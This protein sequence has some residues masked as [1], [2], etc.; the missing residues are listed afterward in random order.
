MS[1]LTKGNYTQ[2]EQKTRNRLKWLLIYIPFVI[3]PLVTPASFIFLGMVNATFFSKQQKT[4]N[5]AKSVAVEKP[6]MQ[7]LPTTPA[8]P[9]SAPRKSNV[10]EIRKT[11]A[12]PLPQPSAAVAVEP[13][14]A[15]APD[16]ETVWGE[17][18]AQAKTRSAL[19]ITR[20]KAKRSGALGAARVAQDRIDTELESAAKVAETALDK[21]TLINIQLEAGR[22]QSIYGEVAALRGLYNISVDELNAQFRDF[23]AESTAAQAALSNGGDAIALEKK[24]RNLSTLLDKK[25]AEV[26]K[27]RRD[28]EQAK[29]KL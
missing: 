10:G 4:P 25:R 3:L 17:Q 13:T 6:A 18:V 26:A 29:A 19:A 7:A 28:H 12:P 5:H 11:E 21:N 16:P 1:I 24:L 9:P 15:P 8:L 27:L 22:L 20:D 2:E 23:I 14:P